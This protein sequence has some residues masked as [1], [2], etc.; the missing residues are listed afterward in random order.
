MQRECVVKQV[1]IYSLYALRGIPL[2][3]LKP[4]QEAYTPAKCLQPFGP[5]NVLNIW[6]FEF[7]I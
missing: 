7:Q 4:V 3:H 1:I 2:K 5:D 6:S